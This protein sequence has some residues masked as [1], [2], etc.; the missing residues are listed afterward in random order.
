V[1][2]CV[3]CSTIKPLDE[4]TIDARRKDGR[5][6]YCRSCT[7]ER[8]RESYERN[9]A[10]EAERKRIAYQQ[11]RDRFLQRNRAWRD[12]NRDREREQHKAYYRANPDVF[13]RS[14][15]NRREAIEA[16]AKFRI[17]SRDLERALRRHGGRCVY[18]GMTFGEI[19]VT[20]DHVIPVARGG[21]HGIGNL[22]PACQRC[23]SSKGKRTVTEWRIAS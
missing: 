4:F 8:N 11:N 16:A 9:K 19:R 23:N 20:W 15:A 12:A 2:S 5:N 14:R 22:V 21:A 17:T 1:K 6:V 10:N 13:L 18:C 3:R 7:R